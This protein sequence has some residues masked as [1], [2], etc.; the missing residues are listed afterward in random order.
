MATAS[1]ATYGLLGMLSVRS[2]TGY[3]LTAQVRRSLR[4]IWPSSDGH[5]YREQRR[6]VEL[7][8]AVMEEEPSGRRS[9]KRYT[10]TDAGRDALAAWLATEPDEPHFQIEGVLRTFFGDR[11][12]VGDLLGSMRTTAEKARAMREEM[13]GFVAEYVAPGGPLSMLEEGVGTESDERLEFH[14]RPMYPER[15]HSVALAIDVTTQLLETLDR[16]F[17]AASEEVAD[18]P[19][20]GDAS[21]TPATRRRLEGILAR[22][23]ADA[24]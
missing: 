9:R 22:A 11:G 16:F 15:L 12:D 14:G 23:R 20:A 5:L 19:G 8:W 6:L 17:T 18:W 3:E 1:P 4:F 10:I 2:W 21:P 7:G 13:Y 24:S